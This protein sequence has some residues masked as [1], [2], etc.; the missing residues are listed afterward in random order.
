M[1]ETHCVKSVFIRSF[2]GPYIP[3]FGLN[4]ERY[5]ISLRI[6]SKRGKTQARKTPNMDSEMLSFLLI[7]AHG[8]RGYIRPR[9]LYKKDWLLL[10]VLL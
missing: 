1:K 3:V 9:T 8:A 5:S 7:K 6:R 4:T 2:S 10:M